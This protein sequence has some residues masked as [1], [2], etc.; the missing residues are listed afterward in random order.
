MTASTIGRINLLADSEKIQI[1]SRLIPHELLERFQIPAS[2]KDRQGNPLLE[3]KFSPGKTDVEMKLFHQAG[4][5]DPILYGHL[6][7]TIS[8]QI[9]VLL[10]ILNDPAAQRFDVDQM[11]DGQPTRFGSLQRNIL[12][13][14]A[15]M[16]ANLAPGQVRS[17]LR[18]LSSAIL[19]F[20]E[21]VQSLGHQLYFV[22]PLYYHNAILF[23]RYGFS[24]QVG[25]K[26]LERIEAGFSEGGDLH[27][28]LN[29]STPF[30]NHHGEHSIRLR[31]WAIH[32]GL[33][34][35][36]FTNVTMYKHVGKSAGINTCPSSTW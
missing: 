7:D 36:P 2:F 23:E 18:L 8:G 12:A 25:R 24:Y 3:L 9:H 11:P 26:L 13:E 31:S 5:Q 21:F 34:G 33:L 22:E 19:K 15:A 10:Y 20:E 17:G 1:Y 6:T 30:R 16:Q 29:G 32:D 14:I 4:F 28:L 27:A 35:E